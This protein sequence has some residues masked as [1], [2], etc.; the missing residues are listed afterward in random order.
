M[1]KLFT[2]ACILGL[3]LSAPPVEAIPVLQVG[4]PAGA[5][6]T[7]TYADYIPSLSNP[8]EEDT[9][10][11][12][13]NIIYAAGAYKQDDVIRVGGRYSGP[14]G[15]GK[16]WSDFG[17]NGA[18]FN[19][20]GAVLMAT[21]PDGTLSMG[22]LT[23]NGNSPIYTSSLYEYGFIVPSPPS[24]HAPI[25]NQDYLFFDIGNFLNSPNAVP[26]FAEEPG[27]TGFV[28][29][30][31]KKLLISVTGYEWVHFDVFALVTETEE[32]REVTGSGRKRA[33]KYTT[34][35]SNTDIEGNPGS[36]DATWK[37]D[38]G[39]S[40]EVPEPGTI[41]LLGSGLLGLALFGRRKLRK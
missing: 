16:N 20:A 25:Q 32:V 11:T 27:D 2:A 19:S 34:L 33:V 36:H 5:G 17:F 28:N 18:Y 35:V 24:N 15:T 8:V 10:V 26:N 31:I 22:T 39:G 40:S 14:E 9:A 4:A 7:G 21:V 23:V 29:G 41:V 1:K 12:S 30:E 13:G 38:G 6:D 3:L 37:G